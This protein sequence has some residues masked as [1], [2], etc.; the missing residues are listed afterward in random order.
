MKKIISAV[1]FSI[2]LPSLAH[3]CLPSLP[4]GHYNLGE[5]SNMDR[6]WVISGMVGS[7]KH[8]NSRAELEK[9]KN[10]FVRNCRKKGRK[11]ISEAETYFEGVKEGLSDRFDAAG[12]DAGEHC[13]VFKRLF[14]E[15]ETASI[16]NHVATMRTW[17]GGNI[18]RCKIHFNWKYNEFK[19]LLCY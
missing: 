10:R 18:E 16:D 11:L 7:S 9:L 6:T 4:L 19:G 1:I 12:C 8:A 13:E 15:S 3:A 17:F 2:A 5:W 14:I